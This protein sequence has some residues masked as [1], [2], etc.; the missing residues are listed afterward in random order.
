[1]HSSFSDGENTPDRVLAICKRLGVFFGAITDHDTVDGM[2]QAE[3][4]AKKY[5]IRFLPGIEISSLY[6]DQEIHILGLGIDYNSVSMRR[7]SDYIYSIYM[8]RAIEIIRLIESDPE[9]KWKV[10]PA[11]L[12]KT[13]GVITRDEISRSIVNSGMLPAEF[14]RLYLA[15]G[16]RY[17]VKI[18]KI[19]VAE[20]IEAIKLAGGKA[21][22]AHPAFSLRGSDSKY[23]ILNL[24]K[25]FAS[26]GLYGIE[27]YYKKYTREE[28][29][30]VSKIAEKLGLLRV[31][32]SDFHRTIESLPG[33][34]NVF[35]QQFCPK[36]TFSRLVA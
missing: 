16:K 34:Y 1:M 23:S 32:G 30:N 13:S 25:I 5:G 33:Q 29:V 19:S 21:V 2:P 26:Q 15:D 22:W 12:H 9:F 24:A 10:N 11:I 36:E 3:E 4:A 6:K 8:A 31:P 20:A 14:F 7:Y 35:E 27:T 28:T 17:Y 18:E